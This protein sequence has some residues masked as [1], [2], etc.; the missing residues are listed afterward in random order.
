MD[1]SEELQALWTAVYGEPPFIRAETGV[2]VRVLVDALPP[3]PPY[4][5]EA[6][7]SGDVA[8]GRRLRAA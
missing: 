3:A 2:L 6:E 4:E 5:P 8:E 1:A 7:P